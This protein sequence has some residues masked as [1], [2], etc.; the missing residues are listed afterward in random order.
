MKLFEARENPI[1]VM[2]ERPGNFNVTAEFYRLPKFLKALSENENLEVPVT[3]S[4][5]RELMVLID[6]LNKKGHTGFDIDWD[7]ET[8][9]G[10][11]LI[12]A[13]VAEDTVVE[14]VAGE[15]MGVR[16]YSSWASLSDHMGLTVDF[17]DSIDEAAFAFGEDSQ[18]VL[19]DE[20]ARHPNELLISQFNRYGPA[21]QR[22]EYTEQHLFVDLRQMSI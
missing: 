2:A 16:Y 1:I 7:E 6:Y 12:I 21:G 9:S 13:R 19:L 5:W 22:V 3:V 10:D 8:I 18:W 11:D 20:Y 15:W 14:I 17:G 4:T